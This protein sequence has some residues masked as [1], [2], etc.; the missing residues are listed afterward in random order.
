MIDTETHTDG[1]PYLTPPACV[2]NGWCC[3]CNEHPIG[4]PCGW[5][6]AAWAEHYATHHS[7]EER[8]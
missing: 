6:A 5:N 3:G 8:T 7:G 2:S 1:L 4:K